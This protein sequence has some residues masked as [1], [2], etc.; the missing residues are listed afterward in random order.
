[1]TNRTYDGIES[2]V[3]LISEKIMKIFHVDDVPGSSV[4]HRAM[5]KL[6]MVYLRKLI[7]L[8]I[9]EF[10]KRNMDIAVDISGI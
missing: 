2:Y 1:M 4:I 5:D 7:R 3:E 6:G 8:I 9:M 10:R